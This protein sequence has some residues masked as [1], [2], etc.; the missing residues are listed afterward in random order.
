MTLLL[1]LLFF[2]IQG[3]LSFF[4]SLICT[5]DSHFGILIFSLDVIIACLELLQFLAS[6]I[7]F[8][9]MLLLFVR[10]FI[11]IET[12]FG[13]R[14]TILQLT[15]ALDNFLRRPAESIRLQHLIWIDR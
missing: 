15:V 7:L 5:D 3:F 1:Y 10:I 4:D 8:L 12:S 2:P 13:I 14:K 6:L 9:L 11:P